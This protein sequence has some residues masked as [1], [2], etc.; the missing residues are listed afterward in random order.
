MAGRL[1]PFDL[2]DFFDQY[3]HSQG[4]LNLASSD[5]QPWTTAELQRNGLT[6]PPPALETLKYPNLKPLSDRLK[7]FCAP[8]NGMKILPTAGAAEAI[9]LVLH[10]LAAS[11]NSRKD[12]PIGIPS[13]AY[14]AFAGIAALLDLLSETYA[15]NP[16]RDWE[17][18]LEELETLADRCA[19]LVVIN[20]H[21]PTGHVLPSD[22]LARLA[23]RACAKKC[24]LIIDEV[25]RVPGETPSALALSSDLVVIGS[26]SKTY[27]LPGLRLG[28]IAAAEDRLQRFRTVQQYLSLS[29][30]AVTAAIGADVLA[31]PA[32]FSRAGLIRTNRSIL[33]NWRD[34]NRETISISSP[35]GGTTV[36]L[37]IHRQQ[38]EMSLFHRFFDCG[39]MLAPGRKCFGVPAHRPWFRLGYAIEPEA[40]REGLNKIIAIIATIA[41]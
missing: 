41:R 12:G 1:I 7:A 23:A 38:D 8:P 30:S 15:Y 6:I 26:L 13:P 14:G 39:V 35:Q 17:P 28:W 22:F 32:R 16:N 4:V 37:T 36:C 29:L 3:E 25:F 31:D 11:R 34:Q 33:Q 19:A 27:G 40:L 9:A 5:A 2:E 24:T 20:P 10:E 18:D 21:N